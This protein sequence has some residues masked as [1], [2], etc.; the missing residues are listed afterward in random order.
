M[1][2]DP[3]LLTSDAARV[4]GVTADAVRDME[5]RGVLP[6]VRTASGVRLFSRADVERLAADREAKRGGVAA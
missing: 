3:T 5:R 1:T 2:T 6:A 4:L